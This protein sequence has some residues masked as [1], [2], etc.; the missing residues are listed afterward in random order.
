M[1]NTK[2]IIAEEEGQVFPYVNEDANGNAWFVSTLEKV[3]S[4]NEEIRT[5]DSLNT[6]IKAI[7]TSE[8]LN[9][10]QFKVDST[11]NIRLTSYKPNHLIYSSN[12]PE[13]GFAVFSEMY[14]NPGWQAY[15]D[16]KEVPHERVNYV[17]RAMEIPSGKHTIEFK[18]EP[19]VVKTGSTIALASSIV[20][21]L[22]LLVGLY[23]EFS[24]RRVNSN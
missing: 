15:L 11:A 24:N 2:Y 21:G 14:Y 3:N 12:N 20:F 17:L 6:S 1:V 10:T 4:A 22:L 13:N 19:Q 8:V 5:L 16:A 9:T 23:F 7:T 18:F